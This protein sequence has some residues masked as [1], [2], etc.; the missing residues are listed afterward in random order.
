MSDSGKIVWETSYAAPFKPS[1]AA[2]RRHGTGPKSTPVF[3]DG[4]LYTLGMSGIVTA[5]DAASGKQLWQKPAPPVEPLYHTA[6]SPLVDRGL[7]IVHVGGPQQRRADGIRG[8]HRQRQVGVDRRRPVLRVAN[9][10]RAGGSAPGHHAHAGEPGR[11]CRGD[12]RTAVAA[13]LRGAR[14]PQRRHAHRRRADGDRVGPREERHARS[15]CVRRDGAI[16]PEDVW[17]NAEVTMD[18][19]TGVVIDDTLYGFSPRNSGQFF[20]ID[21]KSGKTLWLTDGRVA[22]NAAIVRAGN[23][24]VALE[25]D[26]E[27]VI[28]R[29]NRGKFEPLRRYTVAESATWAQPVISGSRMSREG[30]LERS[31]SGRCRRPSAASSPGPSRSLLSALARRAATLRSAPASAARTALHLQ[32]RPCRVRRSAAT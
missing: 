28:A 31:R 25:D 12:R 2:T 11:R 13:A 24:W 1:P 10:R 6:M 16:V 30:H 8:G 23:L 17:D 18:M 20:A 21:A 27:L 32:R 7:V 5:F 15:R 14:H 4:R 9:R 26:A 22:E 3:A 19:S 29:A